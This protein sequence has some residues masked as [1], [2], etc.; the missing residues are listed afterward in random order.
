M[1]KLVLTLFLLTSLNCL[2]QRGPFGYGYGIRFG[3]G[4]D[5]DLTFTGGMLLAGG[6]FTYLYGAQ[7]YP[8]LTPGYSTYPNQQQVY[9]VQ[10]IGLSILCLGAGIL[11]EESIRHSLHK[12]G[13]TKNP[14]F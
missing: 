8:F 6:G 14:R 1:K 5:L 12:R 7:V 10:T 9:T 13:K 2:G 11:I 4:N 3:C